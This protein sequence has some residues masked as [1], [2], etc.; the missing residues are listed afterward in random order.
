MDPDNEADLIIQSAP[1]SREMN[2][3]QDR[4]QLCLDRYGCI[5]MY[6]EIS[7]SMMIKREGMPNIPLVFLRPGAVR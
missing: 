6:E 2:L 5:T 4:R 3:R 7:L 1:G